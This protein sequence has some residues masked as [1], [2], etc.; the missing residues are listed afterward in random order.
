[1]SVFKQ[2]WTSPADWTT[3]YCEVYADEA[4]F[5]ALDRIWVPKAL[6]GQYLG[7][8]LAKKYSA[9]DKQVITDM[10]WT[11]ETAVPEKVMEVMKIS[12]ID[13]LATKPYQLVIP[14]QTLT[15]LKTRVVCKATKAELGTTPVDITLW[16]HDAKGAAQV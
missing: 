3:R 14:Q 10:G 8:P 5:K 15:M 13:F 12:R 2:Q 7:K 16:T 6:E 4:A 11:V 1:M 9:I